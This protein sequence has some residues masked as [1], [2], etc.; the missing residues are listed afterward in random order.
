MSDDELGR[1]LAAMAA[2]DAEEQRADVGRVVEAVRGRRRR[3]RGLTGL[4]V[5]AAVLTMF[6]LGRAFWPGGGIA[7]PQPA[8][9]TYPTYAAD[10]VFVGHGLALERDGRTELCLGAVR[11]SRPPQCSGPVLV[12][13]DWAD[14][15]ANAESEGGARFG[16]GYFVGTFDGTAFTLT[17][18]ASADLPRGAELPDRPGPLTA[19][20]PAGSTPAA[21]AG[22]TATWPTDWCVR[23]DAPS[24][25]DLQ[26][27]TDALLGR[28]AGYQGKDGPYH[29]PVLGGGVFVDRLDVDVL[30]ADAATRDWVAQAVS[31]WLDEDDWVM[32]P[33]LVP[34]DPPGDQASTSS[35]PPTTTT[36]SSP[37]T[38]TES[39]S[40]TEPPS[41]GWP[42]YA[43]DQVYGVYS[44]LLD[45]ADGEPYLCLDGWDDTTPPTCGLGAPEVAVDW[46]SV[47]GEQ[48]VDGTTSAEGLWIGSYDGTTFTVVRMTH[49]RPEEQECLVPND[50]GAERTASLA[51]VRSA[52]DAVAADPQLDDALVRAEAIEGEFP[53][54]LLE[55]V[56][57]GG[58]GRA[59]PGRRGTVAHR[60]SAGDPWGVAALRASG[61]HLRG[62]VHV[63][64]VTR[65]RPQ[66]SHAPIAS[67]SSGRPG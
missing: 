32:H 18:A 42:T 58:D 61:R 53:S 29:P 30:V 7:T 67:S 19:P 63:D 22:K 56:V 51:D 59:D 45:P 26:A 62:L 36:D 60:R 41:A 17:Q 37:S 50:G 66:R 25:D 47:E 57:R 40:T 9:T 39:S 34:Y 48:T 20:C 46:D 4:A 10:Q 27:A 11:E 55:V 5:A 2:P 54:L 24:Q 14:L 38:A 6:A 13:L 33:A 49:S 8:D 64:T 21:D 31:P 1:A 44:V 65:R 23:S 35:P 3:N 52:R 12:G 16:D 15:G 43:P 28:L